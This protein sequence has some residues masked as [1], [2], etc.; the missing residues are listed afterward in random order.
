MSLTKAKR[1]WQRLKSDQRRAVYDAIR[2]SPHW[3]TPEPWSCVAWEQAQ[4][5]ALAVL[6]CAEERKKAGRK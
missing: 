1:A 5:A 2:R 6:N 3:D 4:R